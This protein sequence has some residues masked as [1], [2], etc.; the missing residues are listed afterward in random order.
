MTNRNFDKLFEA[1]EAADIQQ[2]TGSG[3]GKYSVSVVNSDGNGKRITLSKSLVEELGL[4][5]H[6]SLIPLKHERVLMLAKTLPFPRASNI[7]LTSKDKRTAYHAEAV[8]LIVTAFNLNYSGG[9][10]SMSFS[11]INFTERDGV[12]IAVVT[13]PASAMLLTADAQEGDGE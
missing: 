9:K 10:T 13:I 6:V 3:S 7:E 2:V 5:G 4:D 1:A 11:D 12:V 8:K